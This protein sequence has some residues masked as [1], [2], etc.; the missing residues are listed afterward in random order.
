MRKSHLLRFCFLF[1]GVGSSPILLVSAAAGLQPPQSTLTEGAGPLLIPARRSP[2]S[3]PTAPPALPAAAEKVTPLTLETQV[4][5]QAGKRVESIRQTV[6]RTADRVHTVSSDGREWLFERNSRDG[7]R[8]FGTLIDHP[9]RALILYDES[10]LRNMLGIRGWAQVLSLGF[11][12]ELLEDLQR[13]TVTRTIDTLRVVRHA[14]DRKDVELREVLWSETDFLPG[15][16]TSMQGGASLQFSVQRIR[17]GV[18]AALLRPAAE[19][20]PAYR[21]IDLAEWLERH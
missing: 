16:F 5:R 13:K 8:G 2:A 6:T 3:P 10:D 19:R 12:H 15:G 18:D 14:T 20:F 9:N 11:D 7:R 1:L 21:V 17:A 4:R